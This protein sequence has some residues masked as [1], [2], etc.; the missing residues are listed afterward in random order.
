MHAKLPLVA[1][2]ALSLAAC[3]GNPTKSNSNAPPPPDKKLLAGKW[4][5]KSDMQ[6]T[7]GYEFADDGACKVSI[8]GMKDPI[9]GHYSWSG[10]R[11]L[12]LEYHPAADAQ[13]KY[14]TA[15]K[16]YKDDVAEQIKSGKLPDRA[17]PS[18]LSAVRDEWP[19][20]ETFRVAISDQPRQLMLT[21]EGG[22]T[23]IFEKAE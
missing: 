9:P 19:A 6:M 23:L 13:E 8:K 3:S 10:D 18:I 14:K 15:V 22:A 21:P 16:A 17:G 11:D 5:N 2:L 20:K 1:M 12:N 7:A 4:K